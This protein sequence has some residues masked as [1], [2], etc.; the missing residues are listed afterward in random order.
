MIKVTFT[1]GQGPQN[2]ADAIF[3]VLPN[4]HTMCC[5]SDINKI[6]AGQS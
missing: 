3:C 4:I 2:S 5:H 1:S 6:Y